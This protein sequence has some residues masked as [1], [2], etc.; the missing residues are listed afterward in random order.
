MYLNS[1]HAS[2]INYLP[3]SFVNF[4]DNVNCAEGE[5]LTLSPVDPPYGG[6]VLQPKKEGINRLC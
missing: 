6:I 1:I 2:Y 3:L 4:K 5:G